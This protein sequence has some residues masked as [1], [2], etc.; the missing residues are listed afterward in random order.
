MGSVLQHQDSFENIYRE[1]NGL[2]GEWNFQ[3][4]LDEIGH[5]DWHRG[6]W[7]NT[8]Y[9][10]FYRR[11]SAHILSRLR[12]ED[13]QTILVI[14]CGFGFDEKNIKTINKTVELWSIDVSIEMLKRAVKNQSPSHFLMGVAENLPF[15]DN[16][17]DRVLAR[18]VIEHVIEPK[19]ML[20][21]IG[22]VLK[23]GGRAV[24]TT[25]NSRSLS[26]T[27]HFDGWVRPRIAR[28][29]RTNLMKPT[30]KNEVPTI[31]RIK[32]D[33]KEAGLTLVEYFWDGALY[34]YLPEWSFLLKAKL[35]RIAHYFSCLE[36][37]RGLASLFCDQVKYVFIKKKTPSLTEP[38]HHGVFLV[39]LGCKKKLN[40]HQTYYECPFCKKRYPLVENIP[41]F[42]A[43]DN[44]ERKDSLFSIKNEK[45][46]KYSA[47]RIR[48]AIFGI[49]SLMGRILYNYFYMGLSLLGTLMVQKNNVQLSH[50]LSEGDAFLTY[51]KQPKA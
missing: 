18:E 50:L 40:L 49:A 22:R 46:E 21:E 37:H 12:L 10:Y 27:N 47:L 28:L 6:K 13:G 39:C 38:Y 1:L 23:K 51:I 20:Q 8:Y 35:P 17:F 25:E 4:P 30:Y 3:F 36:N 19:A 34:K 24:I 29:L 5:F 14:G 45:E 7:T 42:I 16:C 31:G 15:P 44:L 26:P 2:R 33:A 11:F 41:N 9:H 48:R 43:E 32:N